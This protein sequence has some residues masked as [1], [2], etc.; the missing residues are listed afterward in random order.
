MWPGLHSSVIG[1]RD[2]AMP[3]NLLPD[4]RMV[5]PRLTPIPRLPS[6]WNTIMVIAVDQTVVTV[7]V[8]PDLLLL[9]EV[10]VVAAAE[11]MMT[12]VEA[13]EVAMEVVETVTGRHVIM[14]QVSLED[15]NSRKH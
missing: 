12:E 11:M 14:E 1:L 4:S 8:V 7:V 6:Q 5:E 15:I 13:T 3:L 2:K 10:M 9:R